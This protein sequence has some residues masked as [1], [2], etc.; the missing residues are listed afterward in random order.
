MQRRGPSLQ[1]AVRIR[2]RKAWWVGKG[3]GGGGRGKGRERG[4]GGKGEDEP[5]FQHCLSKPVSFR[6]HS[7][8]M[9]SG[10]SHFTASLRWLKRPKGVCVCVCVCVCGGGGVQNRRVG[11][12][13]VVVLGIRARKNIQN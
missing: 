11:R 5:A 7:D 6:I 2:S 8:D 10:A 12:K 4:E 3:G 1:V 9:G 13:G